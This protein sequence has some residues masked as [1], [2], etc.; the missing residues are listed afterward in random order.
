MYSCHDTILM[1]SQEIQGTW[2]LYNMH[3]PFVREKNPVMQHQ[4]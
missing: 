4:F 2:L 3:A 1:S